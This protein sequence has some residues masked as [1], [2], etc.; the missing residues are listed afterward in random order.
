[1]SMK[2]FFIPIC[3]ILFVVCGCSDPSKPKSNEFVVKGKLKNTK[4]EIIL[5]E[6]LLVN[7]TQT[8]DSAKFN[9]DGEFYFKHTI[10]EPGL[11]IGLNSPPF[12]LPHD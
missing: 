11:V 6:E 1:M 8:I 4:G 9:E 7:K 3:L 5:L 2:Y 10:S 12:L